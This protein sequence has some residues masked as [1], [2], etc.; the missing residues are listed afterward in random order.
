MMHT[1][2]YLSPASLLLPEQSLFDHFPPAFV[3]F[4][5]AERLAR[6]IGLFWK[7]LRSSRSANDVLIEMPDAVHDFMIFPWQAVEAAIVYERLDEWLRDVLAEEVEEDWQSSISE[8]KRQ[9]RLSMKA[10]KSPVMRPRQSSGMI[11]MI[12][13]LQGEGMG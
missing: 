10:K 8:G 4:G 12:G 5:G 3:V 1:S 2:E 9:R 6:S 11:R 7:R 13:D